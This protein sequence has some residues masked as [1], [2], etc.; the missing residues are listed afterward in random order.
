M[1]LAQKS[2]ETRELPE[3]VLDRLVRVCAARGLDSMAAELEQVAAFV[4]LDLAEVE[5]RLAGLP[6]RRDVVGRASKHLL[7]LGGKRLR[8]LCV[9]LAARMGTGFG[10]RALE[11]SVAVELVHSATLLHDD[12]VDQGELR[13]GRPAARVVYGNAASVFA[14]DWLLIEAL[15]LVRRTELPEVLDRLLDVI[16]QMIVAEAKQ[17]ESRGTFELDLSTYDAIIEGK[18][19]SLFQWALFAGARAG[20]LPMEQA[21]ALAEFGRQLGLAFQITDDVLDLEGSLRDLEKSPLADVR[22]GKI[23]YPLI[24]AVT[25]EPRLIAMVREI[26][27]LPEGE[28]ISPEAREGLLAALERTGGITEGRARAR[29]HVELANAALA[30]LPEGPRKTA[31][32][33]V[34]EAAVSRV[35]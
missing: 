23:T 3:G 30:A 34:S 26:A 9:A 13:R 25:R 19:A 29:R 7:A 14:G 1:Q 2:Q 15:R 33:L 10:P 17:L 21:E 27:S 24:V 6:V 4:G 5:A 28:A 11:L 20:G 16:D 35:G 18:T 32:L 8:P 31:L 12:V 22:E